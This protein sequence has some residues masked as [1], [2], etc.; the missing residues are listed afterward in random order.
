MD[1][2]ATTYMYQNPNDSGQRGSQRPNNGGNDSNPGGGSNGNSILFRVVI[3]L[4]AVGAVV[5]LF[6][7]FTQSGTPSSG[8]SMDIPYSKFYSEVQARHVEQVTFQGTTDG[9]GVFKTAET[10]VDSSNT[11]HT[12]VNFHFIQLPNGDPRLINLLLQ[13]GVS[14]SA[15]PVNNNDFLYILINFLPWILALGL[16]FFIFR[17]ASQSQ[18]NIFSFGKSR[19]KMV[20][21]DRPSTTFADVA[22][23]D[24]AKS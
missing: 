19:A 10:I 14:F 11:P 12:G 13:N 9:Y 1:A 18:Q 21:E 3:L 17:R 16:F 20:L 7:L 2:Q 8:N 15:T 22:G 5:Y 6:S 23:V 4:V 24:E